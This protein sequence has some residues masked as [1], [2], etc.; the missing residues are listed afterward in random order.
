MSTNTQPATMRVEEAAELLAVSRDLAYREIR[1]R[2][3]LNGI[4]AIRVG[5]RLILPRRPFME[6]LG[7]I[8]GDR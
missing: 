5:R 8:D 3:E 4:K 7:L 2:G 6:S 1:T